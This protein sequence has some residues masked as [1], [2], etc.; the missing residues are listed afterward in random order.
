[1]NLSLNGLA[2]ACRGELEIGNHYSISKEESK[3]KNICI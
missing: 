2:G 3:T 1:M